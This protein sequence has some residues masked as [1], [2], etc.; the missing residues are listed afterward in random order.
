ML[1]EGDVTSRHDFRFVPLVVGDSSEGDVVL[2][3]PSRFVMPSGGMDGLDAVMFAFPFS[4]SGSCS[5]SCD[6]SLNIRL[7]SNTFL[8]LFIICE[9]HRCVCYQA[10]FNLLQIPHRM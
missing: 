7:S 1:I 10:S 4:L 2:G 3:D 9:T 6:S 5:S 8:K